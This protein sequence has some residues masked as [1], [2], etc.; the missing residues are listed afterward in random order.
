M[1]NA[2]NGKLQ[3][4]VLIVQWREEK[5]KLSEIWSSDKNEADESHGSP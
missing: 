3:D 2:Q 1:K 4:I 5:C